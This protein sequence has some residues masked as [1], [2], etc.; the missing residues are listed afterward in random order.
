[1]RE[2]NELKERQ[3]EM[4]MINVDDEEESGVV[5]PAKK[6]KQTIDNAGRGPEDF[7]VEESDTH[8]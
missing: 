8:I 5:H 4:T 7:T 1:M 6:K 3:K 2:Y